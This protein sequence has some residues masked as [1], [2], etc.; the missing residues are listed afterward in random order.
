MVPCSSQSPQWL[1]NNA[2]L[3]TDP[4]QNPRE[5]DR[6]GHT[7]ALSLSEMHKTFF[8]SAVQRAKMYTYLTHFTCRKF[9]TP[10]KDFNCII[11]CACL[12]MCA[13]VCAQ[14]WTCDREPVKSQRT[15]FLNLPEETRSFIQTWVSK[16]KLRS[17]NL[18]SQLSHITRFFEKGQIQT[19]SPRPKSWIQILFKFLRG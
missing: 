11:L 9:I 17:S 8:N 16:I 2:D 19:V 6:F 7:K 5:K 1:L 3:H 12:C 14:T 4:T 13:C 15:T 10:L 18:C